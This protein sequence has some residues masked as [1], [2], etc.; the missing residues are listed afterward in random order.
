MVYFLLRYLI[1]SFPI[2]TICKGKEYSNRPSFIHSRQ[3]TNKNI[4]KFNDTLSSTNWNMIINNQYCQE[5]YSMFHNMFIRLYEEC[6]LLI[7]RKKSIYHSRKTWLTSALKQS[8]KTKN[9]MYVRSLKQPTDTNIRIYKQYRNYLNSLLRKSERKHCADLFIQNKNN[10]RKCWSVI[11]EI[12]NK[13][14][15]STVSNKFKI[16]GNIVT[17]GNTIAENFNKYFVNIG[18]SLAQKVGSNNTDPLSYMKIS[19]CD[20]LCMAVTDSNEVIYII[21][22]L[23]NS[24]PGYDNIQART[25]KSSY[26]L[27]IEPLTHV[28]S[29]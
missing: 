18:S 4:K 27:F 1:I 24:C 19:I 16:N 9:K 10:L 17:Q 3:Y 29:V 11:K 22:T 15:T 6:F 13:N 20:S 26:S 23:K 8:I 28:P 5:S 12:I 7:S 21:M 14:K 2:F 25:V